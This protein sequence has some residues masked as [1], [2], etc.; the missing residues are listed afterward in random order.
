MSRLLS[1]TLGAICTWLCGNSGATAAD[2]L[3]QRAD[4]TFRL[5]HPENERE[6]R[7]LEITPN[8]ANHDAG[9]RVAG[10]GVFN[11]AGNA[12]LLFQHATGLLAVWFMD[13]TK[14][15]GSTLFYPDKPTALNWMLTGAADLDGDA[16]TDLVL[17]RRGPGS[18]D[19]IQIWFLKSPQQ[20]RIASTSPENGPDGFELRA[21]A[22]LDGDGK[23]DLI[24]QQG[25]GSTFEIWKMN[26]ATRVASHRIQLPPADAHGRLG[27]IA[28]L[29]DAGRM[30]LVFQKGEKL[31]FIEL[32]GFGVNGETKVLNIRNLAPGEK[33]VGSGRFLSQAAAS[34][35]QS[36]PPPLPPSGSLRTRLMRWT[37]TESHAASESSG[38]NLPSTNVVRISEAQQTQMIATRATNGL[39][40]LSLPTGTIRFRFRP[41]W[42]RQHTM[43]GRG[44]GAGPGSAATLFAIG[45]PAQKPEAGFFSLSVS[46]D[47]DVLELRARNHLGGSLMLR[48]EPAVASIHQSQ[49][50]SNVWSEF[51]V[52][53]DVNRMELW[54][55]TTLLA[56]TNLSTP[57]PYPPESVIQRGLSLGNQPQGNQP[58][59]G[60]FDEVQC[61]N[62]SF[63]DADQTEHSITATITD[64]PP[65]VVLDWRRSPFHPQNI[66]RRLHG[67]TN[68]VEIARGIAGTTWVDTNVVNG[69]LY[70]YTVYN[71]QKPGKS[72]GGIAVAVATPP[73]ESRG[74][75][76]VIVDETIETR[77][78]SEL[79]TFERDLVGDGWEVTRASAA[80]HSDSVWASNPPASNRVRNLIRAEHERQ[81]LTLVVLVGHVVVPY[82]G[83]AAE[84]GHMAKGD[85]HYGAWPTDLFYADL[86]GQWTDIDSNAIPF[87]PAFP[88][89]SNTPGDG[90]FDQNQVPKNAA[91]NSDIEVPVARIDFA[92]LTSH[93]GERLSETALLQRY[94]D[95][96]HRYRHGEL[97]FPSRVVAQ[98]FS[99]S[100][101]NRI[102]FENA[103]HNAH[104][105]F[106]RE[107]DPLI[108]GDLLHSHSPA[109]W[110]YEAGF[111][112]VHVMNNGQP[113]SWTS[114][115]ATTPGRSPSIAFYVLSGSWFGDWNLEA[116]LLRSLLAAKD[117]GLA[118]CW[119]RGYLWRFD[120]LAAGGCLGDAFLE[121]AND[122]DQPP[123]HFG[124]P[125]TLAL[126]GDPTLRAFITQP[127]RNARLTQTREQVNLEW[128]T[129]PPG[130]ACHVYA[131][132]NILG[133]FQKVTAEPV[134]E[135]R[136]T[137]GKT[138]F[139]GTFFALR[140]IERITTGSG[141][142]TNL[143]QMVFLRR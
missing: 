47:G 2:L 67:E 26:A 60:S 143:S 3:L 141:T 76:L 85:N 52:V 98:G 1:A 81:P 15:S 5:A 103:V 117:S 94:F 82:S 112:Y 43:S 19:S 25:E 36:V 13:G 73:L 126:H 99:H 115:D 22:D 34:A 18:R 50:E 24:F 108:V 104:R 16:S 90:K 30:N 84:D 78:Q 64:S 86:D 55:N 113:N 79:R 33:L 111:G 88:E 58:A 49:F 29:F 28:D 14:Q 77:I 119:M 57:I 138:R 130:I 134:N 131:S 42:S 122:A 38:A 35:A 96:N 68:W 127:P 107:P 11:G 17:A 44:S 101:E 137:S 65:S 21:V 69:A 31:S 106:G 59:L 135:G 118:S 83:F 39:P 80:R 23:G 128:Q 89:T 114:A 70:H 45:D 100:V 129:E 10:S 8:H 125:R 109:L 91:G 74:R 123:M 110:G 32:R 9:W 6:A 48:H 62:Y 133:P 56:A 121:T 54:Q 120:M 105:S 116:N 124:A 139:D 66:R 51:T 7:L 27:A 4:G 20:A 72:S 132:A 53:T 97:R 75:V 71:P 37:P 142:F 40:L 63:G 102:L 136:W 140:A 46:A 95:K 93:L 92:R 41:D 61:F 12:D 87:P